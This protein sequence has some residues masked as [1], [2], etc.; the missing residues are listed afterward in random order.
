MS[1]T[2]YFTSYDKHPFAIAEHQRLARVFADLAERSVCAVLSNSDTPETEGLF[3]DWTIQ[4]LQVARAINSRASAR[5]P[6]SELLVVNRPKN[7]KRARPN[8]ANVEAE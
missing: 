7:H 2:A 4:R 6:V 1:A 3:S 5:G 8:R